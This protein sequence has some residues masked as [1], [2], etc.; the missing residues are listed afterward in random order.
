MYM[1]LA[2]YEHQIKVLKAAGIVM[3]MTLKKHTL[4]RG[5]NN[6]FNY[7]FLRKEEGSP[8]DDAEL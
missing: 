1:S 6:I 3:Q 4:R 2:H 5:F 8:L 7:E